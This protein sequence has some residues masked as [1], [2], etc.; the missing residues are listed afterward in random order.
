MNNT[1]FKYITLIW[2]NVN[3]FQHDCLNLSTLQI[4]RLFMCYFICWGKKNTRQRKKT[5]PGETEL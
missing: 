5:A 1:T 3:L 2:K 4:S